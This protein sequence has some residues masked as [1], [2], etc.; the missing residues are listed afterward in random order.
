MDSKKKAIKSQ[1][2]LVVKNIES[3][4]S[5]ELSEN[6]NTN[7][8]IDKAESKSKIERMYNLENLYEQK[9]FNCIHLTE[10]TIQKYS[11][12][13]SKNLKSILF[14]RLPILEWV[15]SYKC[16]EYLLPDLMSGITVGVMNIPQVNEY[17]K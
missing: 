17:F 12:N 1:E 10:K 9:S 13:K 14:K 16:K 3:E 15:T 2:A 6:L 7:T 4:E 5:L 11:K 8:N